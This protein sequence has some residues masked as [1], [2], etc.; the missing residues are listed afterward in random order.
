MPD[1]M[2]AKE[3]IGLPLH[4]IRRRIDLGGRENIR[5]CDAGKHLQT[6]ADIIDQIVQVV[7]YGQ[8]RD[9]PV[10]VV[11]SQSDRSGN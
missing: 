2:N 7:D 8:L 3:I 5:L 9:R 10:G 4:P 6:E 11:D 1:K